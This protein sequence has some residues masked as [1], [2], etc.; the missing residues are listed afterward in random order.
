MDEPCIYKKVNGSARAYLILYADDIHLIGNDIGMLMSIK[1]WVSNRFSMKDLG[2]VICI[3]GIRIY[4]DRV[5]RWICP[6]QSLY[7]EKML[8]K[9]SM[10]NS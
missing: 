9:F 10:E 6:S 4:R 3:L 8:K 7:I 1:L 5:G 2:E